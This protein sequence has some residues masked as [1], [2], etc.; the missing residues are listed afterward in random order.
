MEFGSNT[1]K[2]KRVIVRSGFDDPDFSPP[3]LDFIAIGDEISPLPASSL[4]FL[5]DQLDKKAVEGDVLEDDIELLNKYLLVEKK[6][7]SE[8]AELLSSGYHSLAVA[9]CKLGRF[10]EAEQSIRI[11]IS[12]Y[13]LLSDHFSLDKADE[14]ELT[15][16]IQ[17]DK[18]DALEL[19]GTIQKRIG[20][21]HC[22]S[23]QLLAFYWNHAQ[24]YYEKAAECY[25]L[26]VCA[27]DQN[28][29]LTYYSQ[30]S[31]F[32]EEN[33]PAAARSTLV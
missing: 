3:K 15:G 28:R 21:L 31:R 33:L 6:G 1:A 5:I 9:Y 17:V 20:D 18:A 4:C 24:K 16:K 32:F 27:G 30:I 10:L 12:F 22:A 7:P 19:A 8:S 11:A 26:P 13:E 25:P 23:P 2:K 14:L 29:V